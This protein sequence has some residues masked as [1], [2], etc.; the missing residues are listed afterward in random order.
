MT[1]L[2]CIQSHAIVCVWG[3][4]KSVY[5]SFLYSICLKW[6]VNMCTT[7]NLLTFML[8]TPVNGTATEMPVKVPHWTHWWICTL[9]MMSVNMFYLVAFCCMTDMLHEPF[10]I[11]QYE[12]NVWISR[13]RICYYALWLQIQWPDPER[14]LKAFC[15]NQHFSELLRGLT[16]TLTHWQ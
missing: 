6:F 2:Y 13:V 3:S 15:K 11:Y 16:S 4:L 14:S 8:C 5:A 10:R 7:Q 12:F 1:E 9:F